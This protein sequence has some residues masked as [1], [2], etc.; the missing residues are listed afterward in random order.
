MTAGSPSARVGLALISKNEAERLPNLLNSIAGC[1]DRVVLLDTGSTDDTVKVF[2]DWCLDE[3]ARGKF[4]SQ[5]GHVQWDDD[6]SRAR[7][8]ADHLLVY[9]SPMLDNEH[10]DPLVDWRC[11]A[12]CD[13]VIVGAENIRN[14]C[15]TAQPGTVAYMVDY[16]YAQD[17]TNGACLSYLRRERL[18]KVG[19]SEWFG[20]V[21][22]AQIIRGG[23]IQML[24]PDVLLYR[25]NKQINAESAGSSNT[26]NLRILEKWLVDEPE[27]PRV[28]GYLGVENA[29]QDKH[30]VAI[31][32]YN[33]YLSLKTGWDEERAQIHSRLA[34]SLMALER[35]ED[36]ITVALDAFRVLPQWPDTPLRL[37]EAY[38]ALG[39]NVKAEYWASSAMAMGAPQG[40]L[41][42]VNPLDYTYQ[43]RKLLAGALAAQGRV[44]EA[45]SIGKDALSI[46]VE[47]G[48]YGAMQGWQAD[49]KR[50]H[51]ASTY[52]MAADQLIAHDEQL[53]ALTLLTECVP[54]F[55]IDHPAVVAKRAFLRERIAWAF[56]PVDYTIHY[57]VGGSKPE[58]MIPDGMVNELCEALPRT[59]F[60]LDGVCEQLDVA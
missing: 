34:S 5:V 45:V 35:F 7:I 48:L 29:L 56:K 19:H 25:H 59:G 41:L 30:E 18:V 2:T 22:E 1:F 6:F 51:T 20:R 44:Q 50:E 43:P 13:D 39:D 47:H 17:P 4:T 14:L 26:R 3:H 36:S 9:G 52:C 21:H 11:W 58:D 32:Y 27:N 16:D 53:K 37:A 40:T 31:S 54:V 33:K 10:G 28:L 55:A 46:Y 60:L 12:D 49:L 24:A 38:L 42:I 23:A 8:Q 15:A 57:E